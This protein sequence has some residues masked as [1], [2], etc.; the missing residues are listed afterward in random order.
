LNLRNILVDS[1][2]NLASIVDW[3]CVVAL[4]AWQVCQLPKFLADEPNAF[5]GLPEEPQ[6]TN[7]AER[8]ADNVEWY[9]EKMIDYEASRLREFF[10]EEMQRLS[11][12]WMDTYRREQV[13]RDIVLAFDY[14]DNDI[15][16][17]R[18]LSWAETV[19][20]GIEPK[21][22]LQDGCARRDALE[23]GNWV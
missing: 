6:P 9:K 23:G 11:P 10:F 3:E 16:V 15:T 14:A 22:N 18:T 1:A 21:P 17:Y 12:K 4:P 8:D 2:G 7:D 20:E 13:R 19:L 5:T